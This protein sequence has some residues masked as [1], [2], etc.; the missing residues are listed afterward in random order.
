MVKETRFRHH[1][2]RI[3]ESLY[4]GSQQLDL[5]GIRLDLQDATLKGP[6]TG[7]IT[8]P[9]WQELTLS[10]LVT[11]PDDAIAAI[12][13]VEVNNLGS[14]ANAAYMGFSPIGGIR[15]GRTQY[16][17]CGNVNDRKGSRIIV[18][19]LSTDQSIHYMID[20][21]GGNF[22]YTIKLIGWLLGGTDL[23]RITPPAEAL[24]CKFHV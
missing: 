12:L 5:L 14:A 19:E 20:E 3:E 17:Y 7:T 10:D 2:V 9:P 6:T 16:V 22:D 24:Y 18:V 4:L 11:I 8:T 1:P 13:S 21:V 23:S 15:A